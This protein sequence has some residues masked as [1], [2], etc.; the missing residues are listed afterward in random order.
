MNATKDVTK[1]PCPAWDYDPKTGR[2]R[3]CAGYVQYSP[4]SGTTNLPA[5]HVHT[6]DGITLEEH[7]RRMATWANLRDRS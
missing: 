4:I 6:E 7:K 3:Y 5:D 1:K 2:P